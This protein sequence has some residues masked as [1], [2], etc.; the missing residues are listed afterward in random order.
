[1]QNSNQLKD[2]HRMQCAHTHGN[3]A[4]FYSRVFHALSL[5]QISMPNTALSF[6]V[7]KWKWLSPAWDHTSREEALAPWETPTWNSGICHVYVMPLRSDVK[8]L[9]AD[10][11]GE[12]PLVWLVW[13]YQPMAGSLGTLNANYKFSLCEVASKHHQSFVLFYPVRRMMWITFAFL[14]SLTP[15]WW[16][17]YSYQQ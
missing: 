11:Q 12:A 3:R 5:P 7:R 1:M 15:S 8:P 17:G 2:A 10:L 14:F 4:E 16:Y 6:Q 13:L 9:E